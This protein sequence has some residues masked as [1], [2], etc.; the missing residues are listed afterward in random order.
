M[1]SKQSRATMISPMISPVKSA[2]KETG[3]RNTR[4]ES[5]SCENGMRHGDLKTRK[6]D[7]DDVAPMCV[8]NEEQK[9]NLGY[10]LV[11]SLLPA[12]QLSE[13]SQAAS[14]LQEFV[15]EEL[16]GGS[17]AVDI[18]AEADAQE[19]LELLAELLGLLETGG[20]VGG[21]EVEGLQG[22]FVQVGGFRLNHF[23]GHDTQ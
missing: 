22:L 15:G 20:S 9:G 21:N 14:S 1:I 4:E 17:T 2:V 10:L 16:I 7:P 13:T 23:D 12:E 11:S 19:S 5:G 18:D 6:W 8:V 3:E